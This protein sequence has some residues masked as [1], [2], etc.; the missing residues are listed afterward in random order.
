MWPVT[1]RI[2]KRH[3]VGLRASLAQALKKKKLRYSACF[4]WSDDALGA[5]QLKSDNYYDNIERYSHVVGSSELGVE[6][7]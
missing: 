2:R 6:G 1:C 4:C 5:E 7:G 3:K